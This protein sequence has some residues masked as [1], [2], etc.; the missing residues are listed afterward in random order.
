MFFSVVVTTH[1]S[2]DRIAIALDSLLAQEE[3]K[4]E[5][6]VVDDKSGDLDKLRWVLSEY[7]GKLDIKLITRSEKG[8]ASISRNVGVRHA[9][10]DIVLFLD[11]DDEFCHEKIEELSNFIGNADISN[12]SL[13]INNF[14]VCINGNTF[15]EYYHHTFPLSMIDDYMFWE[16]NLIQTS[17]IAASKEFLLSYPFDESLTRF[18]D[19]AFLVSCK[20]SG[21]DCIVYSRKLLS[22]W[23]RAESYNEKMKNAGQN[24]ALI[25]KFMSSY[26]DV[27][28]KKA[29]FA[30]LLRHRLSV[31]ET[32]GLLKYISCVVLMLFRNPVLFIK[33]FTNKYVKK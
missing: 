6:L 1:N 5:V 12:D 21:G 32:E 7:I 10:G 3:K 16:G 24:N 15:K 8:N 25:D 9:S 13:Y 2:A 31:A 4:F 28:S 18:Q 27:M 17:A 22:K 19:Y 20:K 26:S 29:G 23:N 11:D 33:K 14:S 30:F